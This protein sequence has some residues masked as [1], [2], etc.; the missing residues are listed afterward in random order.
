[1]V[2]TIGPVYLVQQLDPSQAIRELL[3]VGLET[4]QTMRIVFRTLRM[5]Q[6]FKQA[7]CEFK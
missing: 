1:M 3:E 7:D 6:M 5:K 4:G 2:Y